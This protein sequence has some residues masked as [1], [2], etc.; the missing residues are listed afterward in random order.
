[1]TSEQLAILAYLFGALIGWVLR[2]CVEREKE[3]M[4]GYQPKGRASEKDLNDPPKLKTAQED[5]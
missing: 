4:N 5:N 1:M 2:G 3:Q